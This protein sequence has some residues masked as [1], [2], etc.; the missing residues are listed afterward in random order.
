VAF[1][2]DGARIAAGGLD[3]T[4]RVWRLWSTAAEFLCTRIWRNLSSEEWRFYVG[5][6]IPYE[7]TCPAL[8]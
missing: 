7:R 3:G 5:Q 1:S 4:A 8:P 6:D 2:P